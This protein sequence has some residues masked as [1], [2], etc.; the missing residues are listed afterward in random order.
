MGDN[1]SVTV[2]LYLSYKIINNPGSPYKGIDYLNNDFEV[3]S[4]E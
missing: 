4:G 1:V 2:R 3:H